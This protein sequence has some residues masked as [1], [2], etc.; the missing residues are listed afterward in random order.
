[1]SRNAE[2]H[3]AKGDAPYAPVPGGVVL[4]V[5][6]TPRARRDAIDRV[7][8][9][10]DGRPLLQLRIAAPPVEGAANAALIAFVAKAI[11]LRKAD[12]TIKSG[13]LSRVKRLILAGDP[14]TIMK[15]L[16]VWIGAAGH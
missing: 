6:L 8:P 13:E 11:G 16:E 1:M 3:E 12:V 10:S 4:N 2:M 15:R 7:C 14:E 9:D 5:R